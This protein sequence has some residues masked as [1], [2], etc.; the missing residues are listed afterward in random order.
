MF[1]KKA[2]SSWRVKM[3]EKSKEKVKKSPLNWPLNFEPL[4]LKKITLGCHFFCIHWWYVDNIFNF[5]IF[6]FFISFFIHY[7][8]V[9]MSGQL[10]HLCVVKVAILEVKHLYLY[11]LLNIHHTRGRLYILYFSSLLFFLKSI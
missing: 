2:W 4:N 1:H 10:K 3:I 8:K 7:M 6:S 9:I 5:A 11:N